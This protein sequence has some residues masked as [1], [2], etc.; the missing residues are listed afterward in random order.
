MSSLVAVAFAEAAVIPGRRRQ[1][2]DR[3][4][5]GHR[6][7][8]DDAVGVGDDHEVTADDRQALEGPHVGDVLKSGLL[9][10]DRLGD[11]LVVL[12]GMQ[13]GR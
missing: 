2:G 11:E 6:G 10:D 9:G 3:D 1:V 12:A 7:V 13:T 5:L 8:L 4:R